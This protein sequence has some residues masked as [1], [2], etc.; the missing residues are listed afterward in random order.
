YFLP[1]SHLYFG[2]RGAESGGYLRAWVVNEE[3]HTIPMPAAV[4]VGRPRADTLDANPPRIL[5]GREY[6]LLQKSNRLLSM[7]GVTPTNG[8]P[9][10]AARAFSFEIIP[11]ANGNLVFELTPRRNTVAPVGE[12]KLSRH[13]PDTPEFTAVV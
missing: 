11:H 13:A 5:S 2:A 10:Q 6:T 3:K 4:L 1:E 9:I 7:S 8:P 12:W